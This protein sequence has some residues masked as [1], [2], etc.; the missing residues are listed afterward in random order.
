[1]AEGP[2]QESLPS[3]WP[4]VPVTVL[5]AGL[6]KKKHKKKMPLSEEKNTISAKKALFDI[7]SSLKGILFT[8]FTQ[9]MPFQHV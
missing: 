6:S 1:M 7:I 2:H 9:N 4:M 5:P 8:F 3:P